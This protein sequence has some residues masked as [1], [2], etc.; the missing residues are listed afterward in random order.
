[1]ERP[2]QIQRNRTH[3][4]DPYY[5]LIVSLVKQDVSRKRI[6]EVL[7]KKGYQK[8]FSRL[9]DYLHKLQKHQGNNEQSQKIHKVPRQ[10]LH[11]YLW[12]KLPEGQ[13][14]HAIDLLL[15]KECGAKRITATPRPVSA[16][17]AHP[18]RIGCVGSLDRTHKKTG[19]KELNQFEHYLRSDWQAVQNAIVYQWSNGLIEGPVNRIKVIKRQMYGRANFDLLRLKV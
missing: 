1:M 7:Q 3:S 16:D 8:S 18:K 13:E 4:A 15:K 9:K 5:S 12:S 11:S 6:F 19:I 14:K 10:K 17:Y 2:P